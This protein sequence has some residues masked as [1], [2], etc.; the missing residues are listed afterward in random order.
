MNIAVSPE[1]IQRQE[2]LVEA[3]GS[4]RKDLSTFNQENKEYSKHKLTTKDWPT[5]DGKQQYIKDHAAFRIKL[6]KL[7]SFC[8]FIQISTRGQLFE[9]T[10]KYL[11]LEPLHLP[12]PAKPSLMRQIVGKVYKGKKSS[13]AHESKGTSSTSS[14]RELITEE[15]RLEEGSNDFR[16]EPAG[17]LTG[18]TLDVGMDMDPGLTSG[19]LKTLNEL[20]HE[21]M[22]TKTARELRYHNK[23]H[24]E[25][26]ER[27]YL[28][29]FVFRTVELMYKNG[30]IS[31]EDL[32]EFLKDEETRKL[33]GTNN[34]ATRH[35]HRNLLSKMWTAPTCQP[36]KPRR[37]TR[38]IWPVCTVRP[39]EIVLR[40]APECPVK[41]NAPDLAREINRIELVEV[42]AS[43]GKGA[44]SRSVASVGELNKASQ[45]EPRRDS[46]AGSLSRD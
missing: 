16:V 44:R 31:H 22:S 34:F 11:E 33:A 8:H 40:L 21:I 2:S 23:I 19:W 20:L 46:P 45:Q 1:W 10:G 42:A 38:R 3:L 27:F 28:Q 25:G 4:L 29:Q 12:A 9:L 35:I 15:Q 26:F 7:E 13:K 5:K 24:L 39:E 17:K 41:I 32:K 36:E 6:D 14:I 30:I 37:S 43:A 18:D